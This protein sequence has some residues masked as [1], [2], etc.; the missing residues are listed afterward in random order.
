MKNISIKG[1][2]LGVI[3]I[4]IIDVA[5]GIVGVL[6][7]A[8]D[9]SEESLNAMLQSQGLLLWSLFIGTFSTI[10]GGFIAAKIGKL[11]PYKNAVVIGV[12]GIISGALLV[13]GGSPL[14]F[15]IAGFVSVVPAAL[16]GGFFGAY[17][18]SEALA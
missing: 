1:I 7:F 2:I 3:A 15:D 14:W 12:L 10:A 4:V 16:L 13:D 6:L 9:M 8:S 11:A 18:K 17:K 5:G